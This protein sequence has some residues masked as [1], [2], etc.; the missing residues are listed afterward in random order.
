MGRPASQYL[1]RM[2]PSKLDGMRIKN[3]RNEANNKGRRSM[4]KNIGAA[5]ALCLLVAACA[6]VPKD[7]ALQAA[8]HTQAAISAFEKGDLRRGV[9]QV[10][11][12]STKQNGPAHLRQTFTTNPSALAALVNGVED[13]IAASTGPSELKSIFRRV[14]KI[15]SG[16]YLDAGTTTRIETVLMARIDSKIDSGA[17]VLDEGTLEMSGL[18]GT[19]KMEK[20]FGRTMEAYGDP[21]FEDR[22]MKSVLSYLAT[23]GANSVT[24]ATFRASLPRLN[25]RADEL[26]VLE[27]FAPEFVVKRRRDISLDAY[28]S[29]KNADRLF[30]D[31]LMGK[32]AK[33]IRG[34]SWIREPKPDAIELV[35]ER[36]RNDEKEIP[37]TSRTIT[38]A[39]HQVD[40]G[41]ALLLM[42]QNASYQFDLRTGGAE[43]E[44][45]YVVSLF[46]GGKR[47]SE[48]VVRGKLG[49]SSISC[50]NARIVNVFGG[51]TAATFLANNDMRSV[52]GSGGKKTSM[53]DL[54]SQLL[55]AITAK[56]LEHPDISRIHQM[57]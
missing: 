16:G 28:V 39:Y 55:T 49:G 40:F 3:A 18:L 37:S 27:P 20:M 33:D 54:R 50:E 48:E 53:D 41:S 36:V 30:A 9:L 6:S 1:S 44:Y 34:V 38:Y 57:N 23:V 22:D 35:V 24:T 5:L 14:R 7:P 29:V 17:L 42:P 15:S 4:N 2:R 46:R 21:S 12:A 13:L 52:C 11:I 8:H 45:G 43:I 26:S 31:D 32:L 56:V 47:I 19:T 51:V 25:V 10:E